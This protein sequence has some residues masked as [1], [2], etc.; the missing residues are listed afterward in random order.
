LL[1][2]A[3]AAAIQLAGC[4]PQVFQGNA[5]K[6]PAAV[7]EYKIAN[8]EKV[9]I[10][11]SG[12]D[13]LT[14]DYLVDPEG[15]VAF[16]L[17]GK[18]QAAGLSPHQ[19]EANLTAKLKGRYLVNPH[20]FVETLSSRPFYVIGEAKSPGEFPYK[21]G[22]NVITAVAL[23]GGYTPRASDSYVYIKR[24]SEAAEQKYPADP[25]VAIYPGDIIRVPERYF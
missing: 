11:V 10:I 21:P 13:K 25:T 22:L 19:L 4:A 20:I 24:A 5:V 7:P 16:P 18:V 17:I 12:E 3:I 6:T 1:I 9:R 2:A 8:G 15:Q 23:A 14:G